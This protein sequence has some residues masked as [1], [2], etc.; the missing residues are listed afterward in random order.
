[1]VLKQI[2]QSNICDATVI[3]ARAFV[4]QRNAIT[5]QREFALPPVRLLS[6]ANKKLL[7]LIATLFLTTS[8][9]CFSP[10]QAANEEPLNG[11]VGS[12]QSASAAPAIRK[13]TDKTSTA[14]NLPSF[15]PHGNYPPALFPSGWEPI[16]DPVL[17]ERI[18]ES[19]KSL[20]KNSSAK[21]ISC[22]VRKLECY[23]DCRIVE[24]NISPKSVY[25]WLFADGVWVLLNGTSA[26]IY[27]F[28]S[29]SPPKLE[30]DKAAMEYLV[31]F[32]SSLTAGDGRFRVLHSSKS[33][34]RFL[35]DGAELNLPNVKISSPEVVSRS[36]GTVFLRT[37]L[38]YARNIS[39]ANFKISESGTV[40]ML[41]DNLIAS[42]LP[43]LGERYV[44]GGAQFFV[45]SITVAENDVE[46]VNRY[47][48]AATQGDAE[49]QNSLGKMYATGNG[50]KKNF[51]EAASWYKK[52]ASQGHVEAQRKLALLYDAG[53]G[54]KESRIEATKW[55]RAAALQGD[56][57]A[58]SELGLRYLHGLGVTKNPT[59][60][61]KWYRSSADQGYAAGQHS[62]ALMYDA[63]EGIAQDQLKAAEWQQKAAVQGHTQAQH[64]LARMY[65]RGEGV[66]KNSNMAF[67]WMKKAAE[68][69]DAVSMNAVGYMLHQGNGTAR[70]DVAAAKWYRKSAE[71]GDSEAMRNLGVMYTNGWGVGQ[72]LGEAKKWLLKAANQGNVLARELLSSLK[73]QGE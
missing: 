4:N 45:K 67:Q 39:S 53:V 11:S 61:I 46:A 30:S 73:K 27:D 50:V 15:P 34:P 1:M 25:S 2:R 31:L 71:A 18:I 47:K 66:A 17:L 9:G 44:D 33:L 26:P 41:G 72:D 56:A 68:N 23:E 37:H 65:A 19:A 57:E 49:A 12:A 70:D 24:A 22:R 7:M 5:A 35:P 43:V 21:C 20:G 59:T 54:V 29:K 13:E 69:G 6:R 3:D 51:A 62:L 38:L 64:H 8:V 60:A 14:V 55:Y 32:I 36:K 28:N 10:S 52:A 48:K 63:G 16:S 42:E 58:Q 40:E